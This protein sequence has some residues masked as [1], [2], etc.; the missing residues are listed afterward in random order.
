MLKELPT[1]RFWAL[2]VVA[3]CFGAGYLTHAVR[4]W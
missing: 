4:W 3:L 1:Q 2:W